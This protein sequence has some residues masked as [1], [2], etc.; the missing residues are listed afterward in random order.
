[1]NK[2]DEKYLALL[3][4]DFY[5]VEVD[6]DG[7]RT[8]INE[9]YLYDTGDE[10]EKPYR[11]VCLSGFELDLSVWDERGEEYREEKECECEQYIEDFSEEEAIYALKMLAKDAIPLPMEMVT[12]ETLEGFY[13]DMPSFDFNKNYKLGEEL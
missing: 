6:D 13:V 10:E 4:K 2:C 11:M 5:R 7:K 1:M 3:D 9:S 12:N 8:I